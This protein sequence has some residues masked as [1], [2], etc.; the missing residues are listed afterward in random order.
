VERRCAQHDE[1]LT[2]ESSVS[3]PFRR[4]R[5]EKSRVPEETLWKC[6]MGINTEAEP[7]KDLKEDVY[8]VTA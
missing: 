4:E 8:K 6:P 2:D 7:M 3:A 1:W 5:V